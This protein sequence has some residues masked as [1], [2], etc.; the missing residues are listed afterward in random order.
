MSLERL[1]L[2]SVRSEQIKIGD[3]WVERNHGKIVKEL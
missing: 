1:V 3:V 2:I